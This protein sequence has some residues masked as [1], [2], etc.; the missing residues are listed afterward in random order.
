MA[1]I[2]TSL[3]PRA[4]RGRSSW[5]FLTCEAESWVCH[6][7]NHGPECSFVGF[8]RSRVC[9]SSQRPEIEC[10]NTFLERRLFSA[11]DA[12]AGR[13]IYMATNIL[14]RI[15]AHKTKAEDIGSSAFACRSLPTLRIAGI[16]A[17]DALDSAFPWAFAC[18]GQFA[19]WSLA[20]RK[21]PE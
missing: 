14:P 8:R 9:V 6:C 11:L 21:K 13:K 10:H 19:D 4:Y 20:A 5:P 3:I 18:L 12:L 7:Q 2:V 15:L 16:S 1:T 17:Y